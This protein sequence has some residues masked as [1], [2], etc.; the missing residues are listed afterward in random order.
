MGQC[1]DTGPYRVEVYEPGAEGCPENGELAWLEDTGKFQVHGT[2]WVEIAYVGAY[3]PV[4]GGTFTGPVHFGTETTM[5]GTGGLPILQFNRNENVASFRW[6]I[7]GTTLLLQSS[8][9]GV[10]WNTVD[11]WAR[12]PA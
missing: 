1:R 7:A 10:A 9:D 2:N 3:V 5:D 8:D 12:I 4:T 6:V 11:S